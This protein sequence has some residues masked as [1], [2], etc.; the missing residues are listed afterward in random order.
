MKNNELLTVFRFDASGFFAGASSWQFVNGEFLK[1]DDATDVCPWGDKQP[2]ATKF[3]RWNGAA[4]E[5]I[6]KPASAA[7]LVGVWV[8]HD[9]QT[10]HDLQMRELVEHHGKEPGYRII[11][12]EHNA[13][14]IER[15]PEPPKEEKEAAAL[16]EQME[17]FD[18]KLADL[19]DRMML[20]L[21]DNDDAALE[22][23]RKEYNALMEA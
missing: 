8:P 10:L 14:S 2:D 15:I 1:T 5:V 7:D 11:R 21:L 18:K 13:W 20:A 19:K 9:A 3:Y 6:A 12:D 4:W 17:E 23:A 16:N 22:E